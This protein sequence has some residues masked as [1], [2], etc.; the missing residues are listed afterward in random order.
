V[1]KRDLARYL[2]AVVVGTLLWQ[3]GS[4]PWDVIGLVVIVLA[5]L[6]LSW[7]RAILAGRADRPD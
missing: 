1:A 2:A 7:H 4:S 3:L 5:F 6:A